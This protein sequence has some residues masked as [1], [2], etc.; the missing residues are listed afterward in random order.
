M[1]LVRSSDVTN[2][3]GTWSCDGE[4]ACCQELSPAASIPGNSPSGLP[5]GPPGSVLGTYIRFG[6]RKEK[7]ELK[8]LS[9]LALFSFSNQLYK[10]MLQFLKGLYLPSH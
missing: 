7:Q 3:A 4:Q 9:I 2:E 8:K 1:L 6:E 5:R 10:I